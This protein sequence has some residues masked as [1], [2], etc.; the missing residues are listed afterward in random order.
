[1][2]AKNNAENVYTGKESTESKGHTNTCHIGENRPS[3]HKH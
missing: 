1:M 3:A 2:K